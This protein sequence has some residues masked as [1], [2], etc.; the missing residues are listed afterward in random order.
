MT[1]DILR[2]ELDAARD[3]ILAGSAREKLLAA[4]LTA[5][6]EINAALRHEIRRLRHMPHTERDVATES[7]HPALCRKDQDHG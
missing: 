2:A 5:Q 6:T 3:A 1:K 7:I 4:Q